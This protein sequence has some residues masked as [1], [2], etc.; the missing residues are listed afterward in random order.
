MFVYLSSRTA[1]EGGLSLPDRGSV[2]VFLPGLGEIHYMQ[3]ALSKLVRKRWVLCVY[4]C[5]FSGGVSGA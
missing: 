3:E 4:M 2:L 5:T 1:R